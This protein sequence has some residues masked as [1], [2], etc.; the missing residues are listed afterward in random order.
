VVRLL[1]VEGDNHTPDIRDGKK[2]TLVVRKKGSVSAA[3][4]DINYKYIAKGRPACQ[5]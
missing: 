5:D 1:G 3:G 4:Y 2:E